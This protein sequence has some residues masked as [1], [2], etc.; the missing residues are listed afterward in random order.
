ME[1]LNDVL[2]EFHNR[3][4][5]LLIR[6]CIRGGHLKGL[7]DLGATLADFEETQAMKIAL[8]DRQKEIVLWLRSQDVPWPKNP[9]E[10]ETVFPGNVDVWSKEDPLGCAQVVSKWEKDT[11]VSRMGRREQIKNSEAL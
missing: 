9:E 3:T 11:L 4:Q 5:W 6:Q 8:S 7:Q 2:D 1:D 10:M